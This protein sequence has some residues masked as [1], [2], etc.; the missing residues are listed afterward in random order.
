M[1]RA[2]GGGRG[3]VLDVFRLRPA[4]AHVVE[5]RAF[6]AGVGERQ[7]RKAARR[8]HHQRR[9]ERAGMEAVSDRQ[10][11]AAGLPFARRHRF[12]RDEQI[13]Q[14]AGAGQADLVGGVEH[15]CRRAQQVA[16]VTE[17]ERLQERLRRQAAPAAEQMMQIGGG[18]AGGVGDGFDL[19][20]RAPIAADMG[21]GAA[22]DVIIGRRGRRAGRGRES[23]RTRSGF[24]GHVMQLFR[25]ASQRQTTRFLPS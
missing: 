13:V 14:P 22:H 9:A 4:R 5:R 20:L 7:A 21:D 15:A 2:V 17:R 18:D 19:G 24:D 10:P 11:F 16:R 25:A 23:G 12:V 3:E 8:H 1:R 6:L